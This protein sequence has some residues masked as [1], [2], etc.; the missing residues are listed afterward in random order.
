[1]DNKLNPGVTLFKTQFN[2][3]RADFDMSLPIKISMEIFERY[4]E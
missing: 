3:I 1:M 4:Y 2:E